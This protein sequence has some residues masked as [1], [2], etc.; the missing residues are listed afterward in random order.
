M[1]KLKGKI[2]LVDDDNYERELLESALKKRGW[3]ARVE[4][5]DNAEDALDHLKR[6]DEEIFL[7]ISDMNMPKMNGMDFKMAIDNDLK[8]RE[9]SIP[10]IFATSTSV[11][12][13]ITQAFDYRVQGYFQKPTRTEEQA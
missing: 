7:I 2:I 13:E 12:S 10:F 9:K 5:F 1:I 11:R 8:L 3:D 4:Y 6:N